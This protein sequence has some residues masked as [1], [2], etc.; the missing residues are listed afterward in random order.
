M[1]LNLAKPVFL[2]Y[3][4]KH[5]ISKYSTLNVEMFTFAMKTIICLEKCCF[6]KDTPL[7]LIAQRAHT[8]ARTHTHTYLNLI[9]AK[10]FN[11]RIN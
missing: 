6:D 11:V 3:C 5:R 8:H 9:G 7:Q 1:K 2:I 10:A 4:F